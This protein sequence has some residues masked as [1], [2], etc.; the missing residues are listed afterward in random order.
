MTSRADLHK[1]LP[2][3]RQKLWSKFAAWDE[4]YFP[5]ELGL[6]LE[7]V[8]EDYSR[9]RLPYRP[10]LRQPAGVVHGGAIASLI[11]T[12]VVP[13]IGAHYD[14]VPVML[15]IDMQLRYLGAARKTD[16]IAEGWI[17]RRGRSVVFC[18]AE[19]RAESDGSPVAEGWLTY[20]VRLPDDG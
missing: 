11:D 4:V 12:V 15:T 17:T 6:K 16:L 5:Q 7:E 10:E 18:Q 13:A 19:V 9:M 1:P 2:E 3:E 20:Q 14:R 8:R